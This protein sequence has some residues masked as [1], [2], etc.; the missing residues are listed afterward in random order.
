MQL[1]SYHLSERSKKGLC[2]AGALLGAAGALAFLI[3]PGASRPGRRAPF[4]DQNFAHRGLYDP[5]KDIPENSLAAFR[6]AAEKGY[7]VELDVRLTRDGYVVVSHDDNLKRMTG[8][9]KTVSGSTLVEL[10]QLRLQ[11]TAEYIPLF[12]EALDVLTKA[13]VPVI[14]EL[15]TGPRRKELCEKT[16]TI[17][18][19]RPGAFCVEIF[20]P[21][22]VRWF[23][24]HAP[25]MLRGQL[26]SQA[27]D[28]N[29]GFKGFLVSRCLTNFL[30]RPQFI[31]HHVG[32]KALTVRLAEAM[33]AM[34]VRWTAHDRSWEKGSDAVIF[35]GFEPPV[36]IR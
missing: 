30:A 3:A 28:L 14:V 33:G 20:D 12:T 7:G 2:A 24:R 17:L 9:D 11:G 5:Q 6:A 10:W 26:T 8:E 32:P 13:G 27:G 21:Y 35:E 25:D 31:A 18:D 34:R 23:R 29:N 1:P 22:I 19:T 36:R 15:K 16:L 4:L